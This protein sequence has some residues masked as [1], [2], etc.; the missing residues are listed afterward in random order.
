MSARGSLPTPAPTPT[1]KV[2]GKSG[3][4]TGATPR[5]SAIQATQKIS[6]SYRP[7]G[8]LDSQVDSQTWL[9][10]VTSSTTVSDT[11]AT[12]DDAE[13]EDN[14][15]PLS[16]DHANDS[17]DVEF[18]N[19]LPPSKKPKLESPADEAISSLHKYIDILASEL[20]TAVHQCDE[21][22]N[23]LEQVRQ[24][25]SDAEMKVVQ[26][27]KELDA[28]NSANRHLR[29]LARTIGETLINHGP[30]YPDCFC[31]SQQPL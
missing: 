3:G 11:L 6:R 15:S 9:D 14:P 28:A 25:W 2:E 5:P 22:K 21:L 18:V 16:P 30:G 19:S 23:E 17:S 10:Q 24:Q 31:K 29:V 1:M 13:D 7:G 20:A 12:V 26:A 8:M 4:V 27:K